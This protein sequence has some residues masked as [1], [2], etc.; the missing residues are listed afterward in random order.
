M[1]DEVP[2]PTR[3]DLE[4]APL[5]RRE[6]HLLAGHERATLGEVEVEVPAEPEES[7]RPVLHVGG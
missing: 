5:G 7:R 6:P 3:Q 4:Q 2:R 1:E